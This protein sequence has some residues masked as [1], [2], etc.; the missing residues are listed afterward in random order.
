MNALGRLLKHYEDDGFQFQSKD[1][2]WGCRYIGTKKSQ[3]AGPLRLGLLASALGSQHK[4]MIAWFEDGS[5][6]PEKFQSFLV[7]AEKFYYDDKQ[8][9]I[10]DS[11][12]VAT[13]AKLDK[14]P[15]VYLLDHS[16]PKVV[17]KLE[18]K[19]L[20]SKTTG[21][22]GSPP[23]E[24]SR[25]RTT[26]VT[27][28]TSVPSM[29]LDIA[30]LQK[31]IPQPTEKERVIYA[32]EVFPEKPLGAGQ[33]ILVATQE[34]GLLM[35]RVGNDYLTDASFN[36]EKVPGEP[37]AEVDTAGA[38]VRVYDGSREHRLRHKDAELISSLILHLKWAR[39]GYV[40]G[41]MSD[42]NFDM[43]LMSRC[44]S[45]V[46]AG[47]Y[48][49]AVRNGFAVLESRI[50]RESMARANV[51]G[52]QLVDHAFKLGTGQIPVGRDNGEREGAYYLFRGAFQAFRNPTAHEDGLGR[53]VSK[54]AALAQ[55]ALVNLLLEL[56]R[57]GKE[58]FERGVS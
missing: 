17:E 29:I 56:T 3:G 34:R 38:A 45:D 24:P 50:R 31:A 22:P 8:D 5:P 35:R 10:V 47:R 15:V 57:R 25:T 21:E 2:E 44:S 52:I 54:N 37:K 13:P 12:V 43:E 6:P 7:D 4:V 20:G 11:I 48:W 1:V 33:A 16:D 42:L 55:L 18:Y 46:E 19:V 9:A 41:H 49:E 58:Q 27:S 36:W 26:G 53:E 32:W 51:S 14:K 30:T 40:N 23:P 28:A 39:E